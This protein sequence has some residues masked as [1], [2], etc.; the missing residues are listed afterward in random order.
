MRCA[1]TCI[2]NIFIMNRIQL[3]ALPLLLA[4]AIT[5]VS[6][7][8]KT[9]TA[10]NETTT[11]ATVATDTVTTMAPPVVVSADDS[12]TT[13]AKDAV[14]DYPDVTATVSN[15]EVTLSGSVSRDEMPK[16]MAA[17]SATRPKKINNNLT[18]K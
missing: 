11:E 10:T 3:A 15:G 7:K 14:K 12:L 2:S 5:I 9:D 18:V 16:L 1:I 8:G 13:M 6:C 17:V 4:A